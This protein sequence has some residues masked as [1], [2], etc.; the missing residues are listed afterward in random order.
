MLR[1]YKHKTLGKLKQKAFPH[2]PSEVATVSS[3]LTA[4][5]TSQ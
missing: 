3:V 5:V 1:K 2:S 4:Y